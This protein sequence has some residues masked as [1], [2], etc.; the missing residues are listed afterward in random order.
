MKCIR[1]CSYENTDLPYDQE[2]KLSVRESRADKGGRV[3]Q[4][5]LSVLFVVCGGTGGKC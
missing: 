5:P 2:S 4:A 1:C 3:S